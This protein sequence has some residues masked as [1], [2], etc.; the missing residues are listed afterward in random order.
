MRNRLKTFLPNN[1]NTQIAFK[2]KKLNS[3]FEIKDTVNF[4]QKHDLVYHGKCLANNCGYDYIGET[5]PRIS[6]SR[7]T[8]SHLLKHY[9]EKGHQCLQNKDFVIIRVV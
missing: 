4:E 6:E 9:I 2:G 1:F 7:D 8:N 3:C 5:G